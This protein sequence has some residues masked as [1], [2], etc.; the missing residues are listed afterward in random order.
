MKNGFVWSDR[1]PPVYWSLIWTPYNTGVSILIKKRF[2][3]QSD[4]TLDKNKL[5][6]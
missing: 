6:E 1:H 5:E 4:E 2:L 3:T